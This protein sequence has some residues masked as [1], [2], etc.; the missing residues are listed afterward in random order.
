ML[1]LPTWMYLRRSAPRF[2]WEQACRAAEDSSRAA[3][4]HPHLSSWSN[5]IWGLDDDDEYF[6]EYGEYIS[7]DY[8]DLE[9]EFDDEDGFGGDSD[10]EYEFDDGD[11]FGDGMGEDWDEIGDDEDEM[12]LLDSEDGD[13]DDF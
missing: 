5:S 8:D 2:V 3:E 10:D 13:D 11:G 7:D 6:D 9:E 4:E 1:M 12:E